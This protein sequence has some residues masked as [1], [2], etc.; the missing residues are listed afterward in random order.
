MMFGWL[1]WITVSL[2][3]L[4]V[5]ITAMILGAKYAEERKPWAFLLTIVLG[6]YIVWQSLLRLSQHQTLE[7]G[8]DNNFYTFLN[9]SI[10]FFFMHFILFIS[11]CLRL[12]ESYKNH[13]QQMKAERE[14][15]R[16]LRRILKH[17]NQDAKSQRVKK[18]V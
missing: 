13:L 16:Q 14:Q 17:L 18:K 6:F 12:L 7:I 5:I 8:Q 11:L 1:D 10:V 3:V 2:F 9:S 4:P 15:E